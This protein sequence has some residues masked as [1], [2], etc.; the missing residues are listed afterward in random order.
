MN[1]N[2]DL[3]KYDITNVFSPICD[4]PT[5]G[6]M[7]GNFWLGPENNDPIGFFI[8][9]MPQSKFYNITRVT[10][11]NSVLPDF[12]TKEF[13]IAFSQ[14]N[15]DWKTMIRDTFPDFRGSDCQNSTK[16]SYNI[17]AV[18]KFV[19]FIALSHYG[20]APALNYINV[21]WIATHNYKCPSK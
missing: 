5:S 2:A 6:N 17:T 16:V 12:A 21:E 1:S 11:K 7:I 8:I 4:Q 15:T 18:G 13:E 19:R 20:N 14:C 3:T 9:I 10:L